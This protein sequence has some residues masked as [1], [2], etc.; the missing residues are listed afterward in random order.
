M[1]DLLFT[2]SGFFILWMG[3]S[4]IQSILNKYGDMDLYV[5]HLIVVLGAICIPLT[6]QQICEGK[7]GRLALISSAIRT[8]ATPTSLSS[9]G[10]TALP[11]P[12]SESNMKTVYLTQDKIEH[13][14]CVD[15]LSE[16]SGDE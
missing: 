16:R 3:E 8:S 2:L 7:L 11:L 10:R 6:V 4:Q 1:K 12:P 13:G 9:S 5:L 14:S 15:K